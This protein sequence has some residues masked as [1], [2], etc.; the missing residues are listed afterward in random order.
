MRRRISI[1]GRVRPSVRPSVPPSVPRYFQTRTRRI[2]CRVSSLVF[3]SLVYVCFSDSLSRFRGGRGFC[4][5]PFICLL[6]LYISCTISLSFIISESIS[7]FSPL[8][9]SPRS[10]IR[11]L[12]NFFEPSFYFPNSS[13]SYCSFP[14]YT[15]FESNNLAHR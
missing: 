9:F 14:F 1:R 6:F 2:L 7:S 5:L 10:M 11:K 4:H 13:S 8:L 12:F 3:L 15:I